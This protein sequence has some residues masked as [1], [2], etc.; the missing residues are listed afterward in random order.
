MIVLVV[1]HDIYPIIMLLYF[2]IFFF[3][4][5]IPVR[6]PPPPVCNPGHVWSLIVFFHAVIVKRY[7]S[8]Y[9]IQN[10]VPVFVF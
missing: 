8:C 7:T 5:G 2:K 3:G 4:G 9:N 1:Y 10:V 6:A